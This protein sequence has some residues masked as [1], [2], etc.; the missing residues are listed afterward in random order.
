[1]DSQIGNQ[2]AFLTDKYFDVTKAPIDEA[3][4]CLISFL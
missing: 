4:E 1:M 2:K 3:L